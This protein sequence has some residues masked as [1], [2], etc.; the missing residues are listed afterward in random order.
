VVLLVTVA[1]CNQAFSLDRTEL[2]P[3][4][5]DGD[6]V[7]DLADNCPSVANPSQSDDDLDALGDVCDNCPLVA[8]T[9]QADDGDHDGIGDL[10]DPHPANA[11]DCLA[12]LDSFE[13]VGQFAAHWQVVSSQSA[14]DIRPGA[15]NV[16]VAPTELATVG[17]FALGPD[18]SPLDG[19][20]DVQLAAQL[21][22]SSAT[23]R[24]AVVSNATDLT[25]GYRCE[26]YQSGADPWL[27]SRILDP[28][29]T[30]PAEKK[31]S[32][33]PLGDRAFLRLAPARGNGDILVRCRIDYGIAL[34]VAGYRA[35]LTHLAPGHVGL[36]VQSQEV[37]INGIAL[38]RYQPGESCQPTV[39]R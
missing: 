23:T 39:V 14:P 10:C 27:R 25:N 9:S 17:L 22:I 12:V 13:D 37:V 34:G 11:G 2:T 30:L 28:N 6:G 26:L 20:Y 21:T 5:E 7:L 8:N 3:P 19:T 4:D 33:R 35:P 36:V 16:V 18:G 15:G 24:L 29:M 38:Y 1:S 32:S 31:L